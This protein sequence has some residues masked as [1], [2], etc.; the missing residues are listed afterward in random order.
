M[1]ENIAILHN[2][3]TKKDSI[4]YKVL[5]FFIQ[6]TEKKTGGFIRL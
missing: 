6:F 3:N 5:Y 2:Y 4:L 1:K